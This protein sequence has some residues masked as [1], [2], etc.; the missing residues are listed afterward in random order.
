MAMKFVS[1]P[2]Y[3]IERAGFENVKF[4]ESSPGYLTWQNAV[5]FA[6]ER[7]AVLQSAREGLALRIEANGQ[8]N[9][10]DYQATRTA[11]AYVKVDGKWYAA[12]D[13]VANPEQNIILARSQEGYNAHKSNNNWLLPKTDKH[14]AGILDRA[15]KAGRIVEVKESPL[16]LSTRP[17]HPNG[18]SAFGQ[19]KVVQ[20]FTGDIAESYANFLHRKGYKNS[21]VYT[22]TPKSLE[23]LGVTN[24]DAEVR[25]VGLGGNVVIIYLNANNRFSNDGRARGVVHVDR[26]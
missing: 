24:D 8:D 19:N 12:F 23:Q 7:G 3:Q 17:V 26:E 13:D 1:S 21:F 16:E 6:E 18:S 11:V 22:L 2:E 10:N 5:K 15:E 9:A 4:T 25:A 20:A 14:V